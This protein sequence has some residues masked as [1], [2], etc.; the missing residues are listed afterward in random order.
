M[1][2]AVLFADHSPDLRDLCR[3]AAAGCLGVMLDTADKIGGSLLDHLD[4]AS[5]R[6]FV[7]LGKSHRLLCGL[8]GSLRLEDVPVL[9]PLEPDYLGFRGAL[10]WEGQRTAG[11]DPHRCSRIFE[12]VRAGMDTKAVGDVD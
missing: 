3:F 11:L 1:L 4:C 2:D 10:C 7:A 5:L 12:A 8:A 6:E 9:L